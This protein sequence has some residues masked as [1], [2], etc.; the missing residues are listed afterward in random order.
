MNK[1]E[2]KVTE[3]MLQKYKEMVEDTLQPE[4]YRKLGVREDAWWFYENNITPEYFIEIAKLDPTSDIDND[5]VGKYVPYLV[6]I[7]RRFGLYSKAATNCFPDMLKKMEE[8]GYTADQL[9]IKGVYEVA[10]EILSMSE[11]TQQGIIMLYEDTKYQIFRVHNIF[12]YLYM[13]FDAAWDIDLLSESCFWFK[14]DVNNRKHQTCD[15]K[16]FI[17][18]KYNSNTFFFSQ[19][20]YGCDGNVTNIYDLDLSDEAWNFL[21]TLDIYSTQNMIDILENE[22]NW[23]E[24][25]NNKFFGMEAFTPHILESIG[26]GMERLINCVTG[27]TLL[28]KDSKYTGQTYQSI[29]EFYGLGEDSTCMAV[30]SENNFDCVDEDGDFLKRYNYIDFQGNVVFNKWF[31]QVYPITNDGWG[32]VYS[33]EKGGWNMLN[34][35][36]EERWK[37][38]KKYYNMWIRSTFSSKTNKW[39]HKLIATTDNIKTGAE[40]NFL[41][42]IETGEIFEQYI[43]FI[44]SDNIRGTLLDISPL[45]IHRKHRRYDEET[46]IHQDVTDGKIYV[47]NPH[48]LIE[49]GILKALTED[50]VG[51]EYKDVVGFLHNPCTKKDIPVYEYYKKKFEF[52]DN[53]PEYDILYGYD[54]E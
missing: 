46:D 53:V 12:S 40:C 11:H 38:W 13:N 17:K 1:N 32:L 34:V 41:V 23:R 15:Q 9:Q 25:L 18:S 4:K 21:N 24:I 6:E 35:N 42:D 26:L 36:K 50:M 5:V 51:D 39:Y 16:L 19:A 2:V 27:D 20:I 28:I 43:P 14:P 8:K 30:I 44:F 47:K 10:R 54:E 49:E 22:E 31:D 3:V 45:F 48:L 33:D 29:D 52:Y 37:E 7:A